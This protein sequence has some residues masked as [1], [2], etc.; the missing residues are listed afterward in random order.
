[1]IIR[2]VEENTAIGYLVHTFIATDLDS[3]ENGTVTYSIE[4]YSG[5][6]DGLGPYFEIDHDTGKLSVK[7]EIDF[8]KVNFS[9]FPEI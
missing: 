6:E 5:E 3:E 4:S 7:G 2:T 9:S 8:E 1:M